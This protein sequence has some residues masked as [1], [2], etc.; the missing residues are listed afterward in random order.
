MTPAP[1]YSDIASR[2]AA[3]GIMVTA[4][5]V[6][7]I[8]GMLATASDRV[9]KPAAR[10]RAL[11]E[12]VAECKRVASETTFAAEVSAAQREGY[13]QGADMCAITI[14]M[15]AQESLNLFWFDASP[16]L[17]DYGWPTMMT[18]ALLAFAS[19]APSKEVVCT[20]ARVA[21][22]D[23]LI[24]SSG[25]RIRLAGITALERDGSCNSAPDCAAMP[26]VMAK[27]R[28]ELI[29]AGRAYR[30]VIYGRSGSRIVADNHALRC[31]ILASGAAVTWTRFANRYRLPRCP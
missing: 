20:V 23:T 21:D 1:D 24:C 30:F 10:L 22:A 3:S 9:E 12:A 4:A 19:F 16:P 11:D 27:R 17:D 29:A 26:F 6:E 25:L 15:I 5:G 28:V 31:A 18:L 14:A 2:A 7:E 8:A 13:R